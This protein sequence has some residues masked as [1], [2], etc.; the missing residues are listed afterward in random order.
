MPQLAVGRTYLVFT[1][2]P[3]EI[4]LSTTVGLGQGAF[5]INQVGKQEPR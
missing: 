4:G 3:S 2:Q 5:R 1:T